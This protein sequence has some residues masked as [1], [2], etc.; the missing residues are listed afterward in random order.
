MSIDLSPAAFFDLDPFPH[1]AI[2]AGCEFVWQALAGIDAYLWQRLGGRGLDNEGE[3]LPGAHLGPGD[4]VIGPGS[5]VEP[6]AYIAG[7]TLIGAN[8][9]IRHGAYVRGGVI[10]G[11][12]CVVGHASEVKNAI[13]LPGAHA[14]HFAYVGD[15]VLGRRV[16]LGAGTKLSNLTLVSAKDPATGKRPTL[17]LAIE[18]ELYDTGLTKL[19][20]ILGDDA[21]T[22]CN[23]VLNPGV[24]L[25]RRSL[26]YANASVPKGFYPAD[27]IVKLRQT[28][29][30]LPRRQAP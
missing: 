6:G 9:E 15:S 18:G 14:P 3:I 11:D 19:G 29:Q 5:V 27:S 8:C 7:P 1:A 21:Q 17:Q 30:T 13:F 22:G 12:G 4:I 20:A 26:V 23:S 2:F 28:L 25:G 24:L 10:L 16:N